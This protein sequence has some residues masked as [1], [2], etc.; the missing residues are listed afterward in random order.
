MSSLA[1]RNELSQPLPI[2]TV[3]SGE[4]LE[5]GLAHLS[6]SDSHTWLTPELHWQSVVLGRKCSTL[7]AHFRILP[8]R[9]ALVQQ[10]RYLVKEELRDEVKGVQEVGKGGNSYLRQKRRPHPCPIPRKRSVYC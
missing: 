10:T 5:V 4:D 1:A 7:P 8:A 3:Y 6:T 2:P 9:A